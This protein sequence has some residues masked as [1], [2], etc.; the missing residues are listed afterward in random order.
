VSFSLL[1]VCVGLDLLMIGIDV[2]LNN[3]GTD[4]Y[5]KSLFNCDIVKV[6]MIYDEVVKCHSDSRMD[7]F[8]KSHIL[9]GFG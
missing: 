6:K 5:C 3:V 7:D 2:Q 1:D 8:C 4:S 9:L